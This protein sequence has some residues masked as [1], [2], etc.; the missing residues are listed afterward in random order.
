VVTGK[1]RRFYLMNQRTPPGTKLAAQRMLKRGSGHI[2]N[3]ASAAAETPTPGI[4]TYCATKRGV[5]SFTEA[6]RAEYRS[7]GVHFST[8]LPTLT[9]TEMVAGI[10]SAK[11]LKNAEPADVAN[12]IIGLINKPKPRSVV[13]RPVG[14]LLVVQRIVPGR[15]SEALRRAFG[16]DHLFTDAVDVE[17]RKS[18]EQR[19][20]SSS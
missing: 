16:L 2:I 4:A 5:V 3:I 8:V 11:G 13:T 20:R 15:V 6:F 19:V 7:T 10:S 9:N 1:T 17:E 14:V 18:Y 12:A